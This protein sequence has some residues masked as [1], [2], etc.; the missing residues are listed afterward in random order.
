[1][2]KMF[3]RKWRGF[4]AFTFTVVLALAIPGFAFAQ[5]QGTQP[6][7]A[8]P[9]ASVS[10]PATTNL[11]PVVVQGHKLYLPVALQMIKTAL[12]RPVSFTHQNLNKLV[13]QFTG[14]TGTH[15]QR[16]DCRTNCQ[17]WI[18]HEAVQGVHVSTQLCDS[19][20]TDSAPAGPG[21]M[22]ATV[23]NW[24]NWHRVNR[25]ALLE[26]LKKL[27]P[28]D[29]SYTLRV[30]DHGKVVAEYVFDHGDLVSVYKKSTGD[31]AGSD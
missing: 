18:Q 7:H 16:L 5:S 26:L 31:E 28:A 12:K 13:C 14:M 3:L 8:V 11:S 6:V 21:Q 20:N 24:T 25:G 23:A 22:A 9:L 29:S 2:R 30:T 1:M 19:G 17:R 27:P 10:S 15:F 4:T